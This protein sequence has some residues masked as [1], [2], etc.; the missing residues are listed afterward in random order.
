MKIDIQSEEREELFS[1]KKYV[2]KATFSGKTPSRGVIR[3]KL[4]ELSKAQPDCIVIKR[5]SN[6]F[7][8]N[9]A[10]ILA[11]AYD[12]KE[13]IPNIEKKVRQEKPE[14]QAEQKAP[15]QKEEKSKPL[16]ADEKKEDKKPDEKEGA[17]QEKKEEPAKDDKKEGTKEASKEQEKAEDKKE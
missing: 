10:Q 9:N 5:I 12:N 3:K 15:E 13:V 17:P 1:R 7:G 8:L 6:Q 4:S 14:Q 16:D 11:Y 2:L